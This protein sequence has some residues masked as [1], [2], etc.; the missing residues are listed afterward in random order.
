MTTPRKQT[1]KG[2]G[3]QGSPKTSTPAEVSI[4]VPLPGDL[5]RRVRI[6]ALT[7]NMA[8]KDAVTAALEDWVSS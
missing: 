1:T 3:F 4:N 8:L 2:L 7:N 5:H 6:K